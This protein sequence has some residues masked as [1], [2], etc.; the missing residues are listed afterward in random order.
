MP[1]HD[2]DANDGL[3]A[4]ELAHDQCPVRPGTGIAGEDVVAALVGGEL[5][6]W[7]AGDGIAEGGL[8]L[9]LELVGG[10]WGG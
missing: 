3:E 10:R 4:F 5:G 7:F 8:R 1:V 9:L 2:R 6:A